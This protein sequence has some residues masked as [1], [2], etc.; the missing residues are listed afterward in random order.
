MVLKVEINVISVKLHIKCAYTVKKKNVLPRLYL[1]GFCS[2]RIITFG[3]I[4]RLHEFK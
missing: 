2:R 1:V 4:M 3:K